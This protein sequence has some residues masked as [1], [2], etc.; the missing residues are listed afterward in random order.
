MKTL[1]SG[2]VDA[3]LTREQLQG[4]NVVIL[5]ICITISATFLFSVGGHFVLGQNRLE[6]S[7]PPGLC[8]STPFTMRAVDYRAWSCSRGVFV[9]RR[10]P[11]RKQYSGEPQASINIQSQRGLQSLSLRIYSRLQK[12]SSMVGGLRALF[13]GELPQV[14]RR[15]ARGPS[16]I[17]LPALRWGNGN[18]HKN[19]QMQTSHPTSEDVIKMDVV[20]RVSCFCQVVELYCSIGLV[21]TTVSRSLGSNTGLCNICLV[22]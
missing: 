10:A 8:G 18:M 20:W 15:G 12:W 6:P 1:R 16:K 7:R 14:G 2:T 5:S 19:P 11:D 17:P 9:V 21:F 4:H 22:V 13:Q 3:G